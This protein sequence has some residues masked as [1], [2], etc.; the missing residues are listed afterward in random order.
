MIE[1]LSPDEL[2][3][4]ASENLAVHAGWVHEWAE[5]MRVLTTPGLVVPDSGLPCDTFNQVCCA[6]LTESTV[7]AG[8]EAVLSHFA[9]VGR[10]F[11]WWVSPGDQPL[12]LG[13]RLA[14]QGLAAERQKAMAVDLHELAR[15]VPPPPELEIRR[16]GRADELRV[17]AQILSE[18]W[19]PPDGD[20]LRF[21]ERAA[22]V[23]LT[24][25]CPLRLYLGLVDG[26]PVAT[27]EL[28][29]GGGVAGLY[30]VCTRE[31]Y[32]RRGYGAALTLHPLLEARDR[33]MRVAVL[34]TDIDLYERF[35]FFTFGHITEYQP[36][37]TGATVEGR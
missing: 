25:D 21:Y 14:A 22:A 32:R 20:V 27:A 8:I 18:N 5:G 30:N 23:L 13:E 35:G 12:S 36:P 16:V 7:E 1:G 28:A 9:G 15:G 4:A 34:Q 2:A 11:S 26:A 24:D 10:P 37:S 3:H 6:R 17:F 31:S 29:E 33:G 19:S